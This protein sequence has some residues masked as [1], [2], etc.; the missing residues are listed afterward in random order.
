MS[1]LAVKDGVIEAMRSRKYG[2]IFV[3]FAN[4]DMVG[5]TGSFEA[6]KQAVAVVD[7]CV[8][9][10]CGA[11]DEVNAIAMITADHG[12]SEQMWDPQN[13]VPHTQH[14]LN[15]VKLIIYGANCGSLKLKKTGR[16]ADIAPT[17]LQLMKLPKP[18]EMT[19]NS[20]LED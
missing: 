13:N 7:S 20:L 1:A 4:T 9:Q 18:P 5:H 6:A 8:E 2:L 11:I 10:I 12:N 19:G 17:I 15:P 14:T 16:L 3:N